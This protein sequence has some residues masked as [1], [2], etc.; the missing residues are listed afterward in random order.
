MVHKFLVIPSIRE[1]S[2]K[3]FIKA[4]EHKLDCDNVILVED[5]PEKT[6]HINIGKTNYHYSWKEIESEL[7]EH[8]WIISKRDSAIRC[9]GFLMAYRLGADYV[10]TLDDDCYPHSGDPI[11]KSHIIAMDS[12]E[13]WIP[14]LKRTRTRG[15]PYRNL[16]KL[17]S[18]VA[19][20]GFWT[21]VPDL[22]AIQ[23]L[24][25]PETDGF[26]PNVELKEVVPHGQYIP[27]CGMNFCF[28]R[29]VAPLTYFP[30]MGLDQPYSRFDDIWFGIIFK[31]IIDHLGLHLSIGEPFVEHQKASN[32]F[33]NLVKEAP[34]IRMN[35]TF[36]RIIDKI[37]L[38]EQ[39]PVLCMNE[40]G[41]SLQSSDI[42]YV[43]KIGRAISI[44]STL[45]QDNSH[46]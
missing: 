16:G 4:W 5:N 28:K 15:L 13:K 35:E 11:F 42:A 2:L 38:S 43:S 30:L 1:E 10:L 22:D 27:I 45:F 8:S 21:K 34:G 12:H 24:S 39:T 41:V 7:G 23:M 26:Y 25:N 19:N 17:E 3:A 18:V 9:F 6:F 14:S 33:V 40:V 44:W 37:E 31:R 46:V 32:A 29:E 20:M 36:W